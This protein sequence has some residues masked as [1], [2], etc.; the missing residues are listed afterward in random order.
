MHI[1]ID[2]RE[3]LGRKAGIGYYIYGLLIGLDKIDS[4][5]EYFLYADQD[6]NLDLSR[7]RFHKRIFKLPSQ[8]WH[9]AVILD[10]FA[11]RL[12]V[13]HSTFSFIIPTLLGLITVTTIHDA[14]AI[15]FGDT[16][17]LKVKTLHRLFFNFA[18]K[19]TN[20]VIADSFSSKNDIARLTGVKDNKIVV[21]HLA[22]DDDYKPLGEESI[23]V[24]RRKYNI[25]KEYILFNA[26]LEPRKN[27]SRLIRAFHL[28]RNKFGVTHR[29]VLAGK[30]GWLYNEI[31]SLVRNLDLER[32]VIFTNW[33]PDEDLPA[34]YSAAA[35]VAYP[36]LYEGFGLSIL[37]AF[38][39]GT[40]VVTSNISSMPEVAG[41]AAILVDPYDTE[42][43]AES[44]WRVISDE[45]FAKNLREKGFA[46]VKKFSWEKTAKDTLEV[47]KAVQDRK[48]LY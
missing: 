39:C 14:S 5:N 33:V 46:Q 13:F 29:L 34:L 28:M 27:V 41:D 18:A 24:I 4:E 23:N 16:H 47:Y 38:A 17:S 8:L 10:I 48:A 20:R 43:L 31:F 36:S 32:E 45:K 19:R 44:L 3:M 9:F 1:G 22:V 25:P 7:L 11:S 6:F 40:P 21:T 35:V 26:T 30:K 2:I 42:A 12:D 37:K 15:L